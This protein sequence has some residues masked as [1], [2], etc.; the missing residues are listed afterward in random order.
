MKRNKLLSTGRNMKQKLSLLSLLFLSQYTNLEACSGIADPILY[1]GHYYAITTTRMTFDTAKAFAAQEG[2]YLVIPDNSAENSFLN[3][4]VGGGSEAWIGVYDKDY[5]TNYCSGSDCVANSSRFETIKD[6]ALSYTNWQLNEPDN[7]IMTNDIYDGNALVSPLGEHWGILNGN[8]GK[9]YSVGNHTSETNSP[10]KYLALVEFDTKP[11]CYETPSTATDE[12]DSPKCNTQIYDNTTDILSVGQTYDC[13]K[14]SYNN[15]YCPE[16]LAPADT[17][18]DYSD[19]YSV[20]KTGTVVDY[21]AKTTTLTEIPYSFGGFTG[22]FWD[23]YTS[24]GGSGNRITINHG[25][26]SSYLEFDGTKWINISR[27]LY[28]YG[29]EYIAYDITT[30][31]RCVS[32]HYYMK[33]AY[34]QIITYDF[35]TGDLGTGTICITDDLKFAYSFAGQF[36]YGFIY[37]DY[38]MALQLQSNGTLCANHRLDGGCGGDVSII[39]QCNGT[40]ID[41]KCYASLATCLTGYTDNGT[42][43]KKTISYTYYNYLCSEGTAQTTGGDVPKTDPNTSADNTATLDDPINSSTPPDNNCKSLKYTCNSNVRT[44]VWVDNQWMCSPFPCVGGSDTEIAGETA[45]VNDKNNNGWD[46]NGNCAG[47][48]HIFNGQDNRCRNKD[49][50]FGLTGGGCCDKDKVFMGLVQCKENERLLAKKQ[51]AELCHYTGNYCSKKLKLGLI[52]ICI[53]WS[54]SYCCFSSKLARVIHEQ[55][56][57]QV[58]L[59]WGGGDSPNCRGFTPDEFQKLDFSKIDVASAI[60]IPTLNT[61][62]F[63]NQINNTVQNIQNMYQ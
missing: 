47:Q 51:K 40:V 49:I 21:V 43:C 7:Y 61:T 50:F 1:N 44:P 11:T 27:P 32:S 20:A 9:W 60:E 41:G 59:A 46:S 55:G 12:I 45:G 13:Q 48:I 62:D 5:S 4:M 38:A 30:N 3:N 53:Q 14:D 19:A 34:N 17:Y 63:S 57:S 31:G 22:T 16:A 25:S 15:Y 58:G 54:N 10:K 37:N 33:D 56:R 26:L 29:E 23:S 39:K 2:G 6:T 52:K 36:N 8:N 24:G 28:F 42:N 35:G 18:W